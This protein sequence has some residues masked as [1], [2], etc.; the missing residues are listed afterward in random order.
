MNVGLTNASG[1]AQ[2]LAAIAVVDANVDQIEG[3][4]EKIDDAVADGAAGTV[5]SL[6][7]HIGRHDQH[8]HVRERWLGIQ[9]PQTATDWALDTLSPF[10]AISG[11][12]AYGA[13]ANDEAQVLGT[14]DTPII[15]GMTLFDLH[16]ILVV[17][18]SSAT[19]YKLRLV[20][21]TGTMADAITAEQYSEVMV[22]T[23]VAI[24]PP[25]SGAP[26]E[27]KMPRLAMDIKVWCQCWNA[28]NDADISFL[29]GVHE[30]VL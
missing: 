13:D 17:D 19:P 27:V 16:R 26:F 25:S 23:D 15:T 29:V 5:N 4:T 1:N 6:A 7:Y 8:F 12:N 14:A 28:T 10:Q 2:V 3:Y 18:M 24:G 11:N 21:G 22:V 20:W 9:S 30:Y